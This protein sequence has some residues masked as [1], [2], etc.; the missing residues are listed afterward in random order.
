MKMKPNGI[1]MEGMATQVY[2]NT[3]VEYIDETEIVET[4]VEMDTDG[5]DV[6]HFLCPECDSDQE[7]VRVVL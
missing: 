4:H 2:C 6:L 5:Y 3:C 1:G 7:S